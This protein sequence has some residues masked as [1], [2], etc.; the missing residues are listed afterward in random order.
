MSY[1][2]CLNNP[3]ALYS[4]GD[5]SGR[6]AFSIGD[7]IHYG[8][9]YKIFETFCR[10][11]LKKS[12]LDDFSYKGFRIREV[13]ERTGKLN[14]KAFWKSMGKY[15]CDFKIRLSYKNKFAFNMWGV[16]WH[17]LAGSAGRDWGIKK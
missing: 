11:W 14:R 5:A 16:T 12:Y 9:S 8:G 15:E 1:I 6:V 4:W 2:R 7:K 17:Y 13:R 3:E 10:K